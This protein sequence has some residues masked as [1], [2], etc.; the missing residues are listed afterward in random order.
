[1][2]AYIQAD[3][4]SQANQDQIDAE[5]DAA[6][7]A[8][9]VVKQKGLQRVENSL[10]DYACSLLIF[11]DG[12]KS[13]CNPN[14]LNLGTAITM[15]ASLDHFIKQMSTTLTGVATLATSVSS[16]QAS[17]FTVASGTSALA[18]ILRAE[19]LSTEVNID[20]TVILMV[21]TSVLGG[22]VVTRLNLFTG[23]HLYYS[24]GAIVYYNVYKPD[25][26]LLLSGVLSSD[27][28]REKA[29]F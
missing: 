15:K 9:E 28:G 23:G 4:A 14:P 13:S 25:G 26:T 5:K 7:K 3:Q 21:K 18:A 12:T 10:Q 17:L 8:A 29:D 2:N 1:M 24:G 27:S 19:A 22:S 16:L 6:K 11:P 20:K